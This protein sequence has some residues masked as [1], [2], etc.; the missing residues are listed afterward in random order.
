MST[1]RITVT[2]PSKLAERLRQEA[3]QQRRPVSR[4]VAEALAAQEEERIRE[5]MVEGY[6]EFAALNK[7]LAEEWWPIGAVLPRKDWPDD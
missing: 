1:R 2:L 5:L 4:L 3:K 7:E 6:K